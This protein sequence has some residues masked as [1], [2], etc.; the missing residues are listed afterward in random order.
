[1]NLFLRI[2][3][4]VV[5]SAT[6]H[7]DG[8][9]NINNFID[10]TTRSINLPTPQSS[11]GYFDGSGV[12]GATWRAEFVA[13]DGSL[14]GDAVTFRS[15][16]RL[17]FRSPN[18]PDR[19]VTGIPGVPQVITVRVWD[20]A[21]LPTWSDAVTALATGFSPSGTPTAV[22]SYT[23]SYTIPVGTPAPIGAD[24]IMNFQSFNLTTLIPEPGV[25]AL[26]IAGAAVLIWHGLRRNKHGA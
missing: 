22:G 16:G 9:I 13:G 12:F 15:P 24:R 1:M 11:G 3:S 7:A 14:I 2:T 26:A 23:F 19:I 20:T 17:D 18:S 21:V 5:L 25:T 10:G 4:L 6:V 8:P